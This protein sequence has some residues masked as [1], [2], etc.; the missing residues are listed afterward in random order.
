MMAAMGKWITPSVWLIPLLLFSADAH[1]WGLYTHVYFAQLLIWAVP[2]A[3][4]RLR[5]LAQ[6]FPR[7]VM[8][9]ACLPD[10]AI[11]AG[12]VDTDAFDDNHRWETAT[13][14]LDNAATRQEQAIALGYAS[15]LLVD[16]IAH[17]HFVPA[18]ESLWLDVP[19]AT[20]VVAEWAMDAHIQAHLFARPKELL[21]G[22]REHLIPFVTTHFGCH[23]DEAQT[24]IHALASADGWLRGSR[25]HDL[26]YHGGRRLDRHLMRRFDHYIGE[27]SGRLTQLNRLVE[28][29][30]PLWQPEARCRKTARRQ[31]EQHSL[32]RRKLRLPLPG[33]LFQMPKEIEAMAAPIIAPATTSVG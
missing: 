25:L 28:G 9:G 31:V 13:L 8:A 17:N 26:L 15:H 6:E 11:V 7:L 30:I 21:R 20:H 18:H 2:L 12:R 19:L 5:R 10:L 32:R 4:P 22:E 33:E 24:V 14:L 27:T 23:R 29:H 3:D 1:A 16:V